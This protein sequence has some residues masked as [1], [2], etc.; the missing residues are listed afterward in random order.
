MFSGTARLTAAHLSARI[1]ST[2]ISG[3][4]SGIDAASS[5]C[6]KYGRHKLI[7]VFAQFHDALAGGSAAFLPVFQRPAIRRLPLLGDLA[8]PAMVHQS[9]AR[10]GY[11]DVMESAPRP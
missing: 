3:C 1:A 8:P 6:A 7:G 10:V 4:G 9:R 2:V 5:G 11:L